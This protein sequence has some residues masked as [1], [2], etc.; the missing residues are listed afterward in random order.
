MREYVFSLAI[1]LLYK[2]RIALSSSESSWHKIIIGVPQGSILGLLLFNIFW[3]NSFSMMKDFN[4]ASYAKGN[5]TWVSVN[6]MD[7]VVTFLEEVSTK[8]NSSV[9]I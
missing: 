2:D 7:G 4:N 5:T 3:I 6:K 8:L 1:I 9:T